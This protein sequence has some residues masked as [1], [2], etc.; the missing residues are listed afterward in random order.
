EDSSDIEYRETDG[1][2]SA[3]DDARNFIP[4]SR[5]DV[6]TITE[7]FGPFLGIDATMKNSFMARIEYK[8]TRNLSLSFVNNQ[9]TEMRSNEFVTGLGYR[10]KNVKFTVRSLGTGKK[11][12]LKSD[13]NVKA[14]V[15][16][17]DNKTVLRR[18]EQRDNQ[19][20]TGTRQISINTSADYM[21]G[22]KLNI[23]LFYEQTISKPHVSTQIPTST[24]NAGVSMR[25]TL[26]Q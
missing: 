23:R 20:S 4:S 24:T 25:F 17:R 10:F 21:V 2:A 19:V 6:I 3:L 8:K 1:F 14:D 22:P 11:T 5:M 15:S 9:L 26:A 7:Q 16:I 13:L 12:P 18:I